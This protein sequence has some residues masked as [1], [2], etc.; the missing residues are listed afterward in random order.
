MSII[1]RFKSFFLPESFRTIQEDI[2]DWAQA[3]IPK[4][5]WQGN[6]AHLRKEVT[7]LEQEFTDW[8]KCRE[9]SSTDT[10]VSNFFNS[11]SFN[12]THDR[13]R[14]E[15][16]DV[17]VLAC[18]LARIG[19]VD[20]VQAVRDKMVINKK[21]KWSEP[22]EKG[23]I[24]HVEESYP[25]LKEENLSPPPPPRPLLVPMTPVKKKS[26]SKKKVSKRR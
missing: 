17:V 25:P 13:L 19:K 3:S 5:T 15:L 14:K 26:R 7:E 18:H 9:S 10:V 8:D 22:D 2:G 11:V 4:A 6:I 12:K 16:A 20:L 21:R 23:V 1:K 24:H